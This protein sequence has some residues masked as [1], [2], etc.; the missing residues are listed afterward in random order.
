MHIVL[1]IAGSICIG[2]GMSS[3]WVGIGMTLIVIA[4]LFTIETRSGVEG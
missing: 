4:L 1:G 3:W 2:I